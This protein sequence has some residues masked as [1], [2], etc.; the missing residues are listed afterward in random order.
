LKKV[1]VIDLMDEPGHVNTNKRLINILKKTFD[2]TFVAT[3]EYVSQFEDVSVDKIKIKK[4]KI[5][6]GMGLRM[7]QL[8]MLF[9]VKNLI[10]QEQYRLVIFL[11]YETISMSLFTRFLLGKSAKKC[12]VFNHNN[13][14]QLSVSKMKR[15]F[16][17]NM[18]GAVRHLVYESYIK[19]Y[20]IDDFR[21]TVDIISHP[22]PLKHNSGGVKKFQMF[23]PSAGGKVHNF[24]ILEVASRMPGLK[25]FLKGDYV[26]QKNNC[27]IKP[28]YDNYFELLQSST[29]VFVPVDYSYRVSGVVYEALANNCVVIL[30]TSLLAVELKQRFPNEIYIIDKVKDLPEMINSFTSHLPEQPEIFKQHNDDFISQQFDNLL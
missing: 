6:T 30:L 29:F 27:V 21:K 11:A 20:L 18:N 9:G 22:L 8:M 19:K 1:L 4:V 5:P 24:E 16:F 14:D 15:Y 28:N 23:S 7:S 2:V 17:Q 10:A 25:V 3:N 26:F 12:F 13:I